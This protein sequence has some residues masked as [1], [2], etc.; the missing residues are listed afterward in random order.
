MT[1]TMKRGVKGH[2]GIGPLYDYLHIHK[3]R[4]EQQGAAPVPR[5]HHEL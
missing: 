4:E 3:V 2:V 5:K 1:N